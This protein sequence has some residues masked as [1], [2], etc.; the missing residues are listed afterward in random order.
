METLILIDGYS[1]FHRAFY[2]LPPLVNDEGVPTGAVYG[3]ATML[4]RL[5][6]TYKPDYLAVAID[7]PGGTFRHKMYDGYKATRRKMPDELAVQLPIFA[8]MLET[9]GIAAIG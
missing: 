1:L 4:M 7:L 6:D 5:I 2:A 8:K 3:F 9:M